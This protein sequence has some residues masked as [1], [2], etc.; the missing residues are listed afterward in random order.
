[1]ARSYGHISGY[2]KEILELK[3]KISKFMQIVKKS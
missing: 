2:D 3:S 1:M